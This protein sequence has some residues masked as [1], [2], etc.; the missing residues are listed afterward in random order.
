MKF[1]SES[2]HIY[3]GFFIYKFLSTVPHGDKIVLD[4]GKG[5]VYL[6]GTSLRFKDR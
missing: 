3:V 1:S 2:Q 5:N 4:E 6:F